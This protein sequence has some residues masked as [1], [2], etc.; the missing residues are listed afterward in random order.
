[1]I[2]DFDHNKYFRDRYPFMFS[3]AEDPFAGVWDKDLLK[4]HDDLVRWSHYDPVGTADLYL[5]GT[6]LHRNQVDDEILKR[7]ALGARR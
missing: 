3:T 2:A 6:T 1:M 4:V 5:K 7:M